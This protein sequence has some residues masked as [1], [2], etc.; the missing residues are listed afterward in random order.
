LDQKAKLRSDRFVLRSLGLVAVDRILL[1]NSVTACGGH[2][3]IQVHFDTGSP[4]IQGNYCSGWIHNCIDVKSSVGVLVKGNTVNG[5]GSSS[6]SAFYFENPQIPV[7]DITWQSNVVYDAPNG[8]ECEWGGTGSGVSSNC[9]VYNNTA[10]LGY[11][12]AIATGG[13]PTCGKV[14]IDVHNNIF[15]TVSTYYDG[16]N[17]TTPTWDYNNDG[18]S[19]GPVSGPNGSHDLNGVDPLYVDATS[20]D[21]HLSLSSLCIGAGLIGLTLDNLDMGAF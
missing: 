12:S 14:S 2:N 8:F 18:A 7:G 20:H 1:N 21:Y 11:Q 17:C 19:Q 5:A 15:D 6:G 3:C 16:H 10:F 4:L 13:D 9:R